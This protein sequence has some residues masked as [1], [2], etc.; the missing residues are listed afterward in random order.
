MVSHEIR[1]YTHGW[2][3]T[4]PFRLGQLLQGFSLGRLNLGRHTFWSEGSARARVPSSLCDGCQKN[5]TP[6]TTQISRR[7][8]SMH[9]V[10]RH[11]FE[12]CKKMVP[13]AQTRAAPELCQRHLQMLGTKRRVEREKGKRSPTAAQEKWIT[14]H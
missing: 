9:G 11:C 12:P 14:F 7:K 13:R 4:V 5:A 8:H 1:Q 3:C 2:Y 10:E 6:L